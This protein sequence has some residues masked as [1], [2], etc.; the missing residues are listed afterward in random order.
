VTLPN[1]SWVVQT[2]TAY[3]N[4][5]VSVT[6]QAWNFT[7]IARILTGGTIRQLCE[8]GFHKNVQVPS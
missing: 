3:G 8:G 1:P 5:Q 6:R 7:Q 4:F 2:D